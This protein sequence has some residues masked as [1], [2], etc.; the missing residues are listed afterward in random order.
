[1]EKGHIS[2]LLEWLT[3]SI[4]AFY[5]PYIDSLL[6]KLAFVITVPRDIDIVAFKD[7][8]TQPIEDL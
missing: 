4:L 7:Q 2:Y 3:I 8:H 6:T 5:I 1:V